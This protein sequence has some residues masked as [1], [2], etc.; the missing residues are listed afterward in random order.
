MV[1]PENAMI[2][3]CTCLDEFPYERIYCETAEVTQQLID[4]AVQNLILVNNMTIYD[5]STWIRLDKFRVKNSLQLTSLNVSSLNLMT[6]RAIQVYDNPSLLEIF[7]DVNNCEKINVQ[8]LVFYNNNF[9]SES[10]VDFLPFVKDSLNVMDL[11]Q[12]EAEYA[13]STVFEELLDKG[14]GRKTDDIKIS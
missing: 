10:L 7:A 6:V 3:P 4:R 11:C 1:C 8:E 13:P 5:N 2:E 9:T 14:T 12:N